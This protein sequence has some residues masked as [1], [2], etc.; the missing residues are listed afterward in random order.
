MKRKMVDAVEFKLTK[1]KM[2]KNY[3][4]RPMCLGERVLFS[5]TIKGAKV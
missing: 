4:G 3:F 2:L 5:V 1:I